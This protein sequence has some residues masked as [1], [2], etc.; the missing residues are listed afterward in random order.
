[1]GPR[2]DL[3]KVYAEMDV[4][5]LT[6]ASEG[7][8]YVVLE[9]NCAGLP[10]VATDVGACREILTG[11]GKDDRALGPSGR[12]TPVGDPE[13]TASE[14]ARFAR[15]PDALYRY[16]LT[17]RERALRYYDLEKIM[18]QYRD[19][20]ETYIFAAKKP[21]HARATDDARTLPHGVH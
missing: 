4:L 10:V 18:R 13:A 12:I 16:G 9:A 21:R 14:L 1:M 20:Y 6:S 15:D 7:F 5:L 19:I 2:R 3:D 8:P 17:G 11:I